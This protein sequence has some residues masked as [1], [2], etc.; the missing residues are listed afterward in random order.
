MINEKDVYRYFKLLGH[1]NTELRAIAYK[2]KEDKKISYIA[3]V[4]EINCYDDF[5]DFCRKW[6]EKANIYAGIHERRTGGTKTKDVKKINLIAIDIDSNHPINEASTE[7]ELE[8]CKKEAFK[9]LNDLSKEYSNPSII[10][11]GNGFHFIWRI[12]P[13]IITDK[14]RKIIEDKIKEWINQLK[15]KYNSDNKTIDQIGDLARIL[16]VAGT[17][18]VKGNN[19]KERPF[20][21]TYFIEYNDNIS[22]TL[23]DEILTT[24]IKNGTK[25]QGEFK[26]PERGVLGKFDYLLEKDQ[27]L[28]SLYNGNLTGFKSRSEAE[29]SLACKLNYYGF[30]DT[31]ID[32]IMRGSGIGKWSSANKQYKQ[33][34]LTKASLWTREKKE[35]LK[36]INLQD[37]YNVISKWLYIKDFHMIDLMLA[38]VLSQRLKGSPIWMIFVGASGDG[39]SEMVKMIDQL[40]CVYKVDQITQNTLVSG[41]KD[42]IDLAPQLN[43]KLLLITD[44]ASILSLNGDAQRAIFAQ[45]R[46]LYDGEAFKDSGVGA[47]KHY[48]GLRIT[49][50]AN[51]T[52]MINHKI[53]IHQ[54]LG[55]R[56]LLYRTDSKETLED[57]KKKALRALENEGKKKEI[58]DEIRCVVSSFFDNIKA[59]DIKIPDETKEWLFEKAKWLS[60]MRSTATIDF[61]GDLISNVAPEV[62]TRLLMQ[63]RVI[64]SCLR[65][66]SKEYT[67]GR[68]K[69]I[70]FRIINSSA[71]ENRVMIYNYLQNCLKAQTTSAL[72]GALKLG[73]KT[74]KSECSILWN[75]N[76]IACKHERTINFGREQEISYWSKKEKQIEQKAGVSEEYVVTG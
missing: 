15:K 42:V 60:L 26:K 69:E 13:I 9:M 36:N 50:I 33:L 38:I 22:D 2:E 16:K 14:N 5:L 62:P 74:I 47:R 56:E 45:L 4:R 30:S 18:S 59:I 51:S 68:A 20:R 53:L 8:K 55:T 35:D 37:V 71:R 75:L 29:L 54:D 12:R 46:N 19:T 67:D 24:T 23:R 6:N 70:I 73:K 43:K 44:F 64:Y 40:E 1:K 66:L 49:M 76:L 28:S 57:F 58:R 32:L 34:T 65:S 63:L 39:K 61:N 10:M 3:E 52:P 11:T 41:A 27:K 17:K 21:D 25:Q 7:K 48:T 31:E 72:A